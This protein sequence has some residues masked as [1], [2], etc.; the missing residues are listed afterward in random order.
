MHVRDIV[1]IIRVSGAELDEEYI[2]HW[3]EQLGVRTA[4]DRIR[5]QAE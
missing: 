5:K 2:R 4:W 1:G 3:A